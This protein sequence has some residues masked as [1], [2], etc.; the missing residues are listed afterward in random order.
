LNDLP[1]IGQ[2]VLS[3]F[4]NE[5]AQLAQQAPQ[6]VDCPRAV[7][8]PTRTQPMQRADHLL[9]HGLDRYGPDLLIA[10]GLE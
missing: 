5:E 3:S 8:Q 10:E 7:A 1:G 2:H 9:G 6:R 4:W